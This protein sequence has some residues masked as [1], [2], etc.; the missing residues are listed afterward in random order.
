MLRTED[1]GQSWEDFQ[2]PDPLDGESDEIKCISFPTPWRGY[3][4]LYKARELR[5][6][7]VWT[8]TRQTVSLRLVEGW[9]MASINVAPG[10]RAVNDIMMSLVRADALTLMKDHSGNFY[11][12]EREF[13]NIPSP[14]SV[15]QGYLIKVNRDINLT[16]QGERI[17]ADTPIELTDG[18]Q[19]VSYYPRDQFEVPQ[20]L[21]SLDGSLILAK[22]DHGR[23]YRP[24]HNFNNMPAMREGRGY[25]L[26]MENEAELMYPQG[27]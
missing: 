11:N 19:M 16:V 6:V 17:E 14:W 24:S 12:P 21:E 13:N 20:A 3:A 4:G 26:K 23:F 18:W 25:M 10:E 22:D 15:K 1:G 8:D 2:I 5:G 7:Y 27:E 9:N